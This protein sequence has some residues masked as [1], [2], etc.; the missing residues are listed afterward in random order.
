MKKTLL[1]LALGLAVSVSSFAQSLTVDAENAK[2][3][4]KI[5]ADDV[6]GSI[7]GLDATIIFNTDDLSKSSIKGSIP[8]ENINTGNK[9]RDEHLA[10]EEYFDSAKYPTMKFESNKIEKTD[11]GFLMVGKM[12]IKDVSKDVRINFTFDDKTFLGKTVIYTNDF[13]FA[14][15]KKREDSKVLIKFTVPVK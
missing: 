6:T 2:V 8:V 14:V 4:F 7:D 15:A 13:D 5:I 9:T 1:T 10:D 12:T 3:D 11:K